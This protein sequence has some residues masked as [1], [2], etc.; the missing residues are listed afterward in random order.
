MFAQV[1]SVMSSSRLAR[2]NSMTLLELLQAGKTAAK[3]SMGAQGAICIPIGLTGGKRCG[4]SVRYNGH[5]CIAK[6]FLEA[7]G[8]DMD[9]A[10]LAGLGAI[11]ADMQQDL[12]NGEPPLQ[13]FEYLRTCGMLRKKRLR[14]TGWVSARS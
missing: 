8:F 7:E 11:G 14:C 12:A 9:Y 2:V 5:K 3:R 1:L 10:E 6:R 13:P 4:V